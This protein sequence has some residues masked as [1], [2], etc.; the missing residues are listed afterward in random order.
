MKQVQKPGLLV[1]VATCS[2]QQVHQVHLD[3]YAGAHSVES[4]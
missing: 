2:C 3:G 1:Q 4:A